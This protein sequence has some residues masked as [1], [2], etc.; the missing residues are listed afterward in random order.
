MNPKASLHYRQRLKSRSLIESLLKKGTAFN[1]F[2]FRTIVL[3]TPVD[4]ETPE[5]A[6]LQAGFSVSARKFKK[7]VDRNRI[8]RLTKEAYRIQKHLLEEPLRQQKKQA[9]LFFIYT[10]KEKPELTL[11]KEKMDLILN[12]LIRLCSEKA[13]SNT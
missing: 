11:V 7:A 13:A 1:I 3:F 4:N 2:P 12:K 8:K 5:T 10:G 9:V 6:F